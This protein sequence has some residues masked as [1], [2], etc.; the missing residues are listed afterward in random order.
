MKLKD[1][2]LADLLLPIFKFIVN[3]L[4]NWREGEITSNGLKNTE[5][6]V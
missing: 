3:I 4:M 5:V 1:I 6:M 2:E